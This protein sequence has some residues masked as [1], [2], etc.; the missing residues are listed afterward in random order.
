MVQSQEAQLQEREGILTS[1]LYGGDILG[2]PVIVSCR[3]STYYLICVMLFLT[4]CKSQYTKTYHSY[5]RTMRD[6][7]LRGLQRGRLAE[8]LSPLT[9]LLVSL[10]DAV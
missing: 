3:K 4:C 6:L 5:L 8:F 1:D 2:N 7:V 9:V 10:K